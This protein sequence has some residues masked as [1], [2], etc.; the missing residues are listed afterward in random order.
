MKAAPPLVFPSGR[1]LAAWWRQLAPQ[2][3]RSLAVAHLLLHHVEAL[4]LTEHDAPPDP[5]AAFVLRALADAPSF[6]IDDL[7]RRLPVGRQ[8]LGRVL[9][10]A[11][12]AGLVEAEAGRWRLT[13]AGR[14]GG[15]AGAGYERRA[16]RFRD[17]SQ[18]QFVPLD[19]PPGHQVMPPP[20]WRFDPAV[21]RH[22][23][24]QSHAWKRRHHFPAEVRAVLTSDASEA[25]D[26]PPAWRRVVVDRPEHVV[27]ALLVIAGETAEGELRGFAVEPRG[28]LLSGPRP[29]LVMGPGWPETFPEVAAGP[30]AEAWRGAWRGWCQARGVPPAEADACAISRDGVVLHVAAPRDVLG[31]LRSANGEAARDEVWLLAGEGTTRTAA[32]VELASAV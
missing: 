6:A 31:R 20:G 22:C 18:P 32:R 26:E 7:E 23:V 12:A 28:W 5:L 16:F 13:A 9:A 11:S 29:A 15:A 14:A 17:G 2:S 3:P 8:L 24:G 21:L 27:L 4:V 25:P 10:E 1:T 19:V 30:S